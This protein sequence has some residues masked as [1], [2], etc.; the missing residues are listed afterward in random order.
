ME[1]LLRA[2]LAVLYEKKEA[3]RREEDEKL[4]NLMRE[5]DFP[6]LQAPIVNPTAKD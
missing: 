5:D 1:I 4:R 3:A 6:L 2:R